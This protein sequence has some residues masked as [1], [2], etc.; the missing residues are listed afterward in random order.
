[1]ITPTTYITDK[2]LDARTADWLAQIAPY[3]FR[4]RNL[5]ADASAL[6][7]VDMQR[8][9]LEDPFPLACENARVVLQRV[10][11]LITAFRRAGR[12]VIYLAQMNKAINI[13][14]GVQLSNWWTTP[15]LEGSPGVEIHPRLAP[16]PE[17]KVIPKRRYSGFHATDLDLTLRVMK[18]TDVVVCGTLTNVCVEGTVRDA[19]MHDYRVF[20]PAD[21]TASLT[22]EMH[23][24]ALRTMAGWY[25]TVTQTRKIGAALSEPKTKE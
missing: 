25:A 19:F 22:E 17:E 7:I 24:A 5:A 1:M 13:D 20:L 18:V 21:A 2:T 16:R 9:F 4:E 8:C 14:R 23:L 11:Q 10:E 6:L 12:P 3:N 15:P